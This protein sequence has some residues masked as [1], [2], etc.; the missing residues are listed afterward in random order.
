MSDTSV[1]QDFLEIFTLKSLLE[2]LPGHIFWKNKDGKYLGCNKAQAEYY[3]V[4]SS[5]EVINKTDF[6]LL[7]TQAAQKVRDNDLQIMRDGSTTTVIEKN[8]NDYFL[9][10]KSSIKDDFN[11]SIGV[12]G[13]SINI[14]EQKKLEKKLKHQLDTLSE[15]INTKESFLNNLSHELRTPMHIITSI[16]TELF[17]NYYQLSDKEKFEFIGMLKTTSNKAS[18]FIKNILTLAK[19]KKGELSLRLENINI[20]DLIKSI[21]GELAVISVAPIIIKSNKLIQVRC[22]KFQIEQVI[23]NLIENAIKY[24]NNKP[25]HIIISQNPKEVSVEVSDEGIGVPEK[26]KLKIFE[27]FKESSITKS[28][29]GGTGLGLAICK[30]IINLHNGKIWVESGCNSGSRFIFTLPLTL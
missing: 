10:V 22:T 6:D 26:E 8:K 1:A 9:S 23:R 17:D 24:G 12:V 28:F 18:K 3:G 30:D 29:S 27:A 11:N 14:S 4:D 20:V 15:A 25:I 13:C 2:I 7:P 21:V 5:R 19:G 16:A